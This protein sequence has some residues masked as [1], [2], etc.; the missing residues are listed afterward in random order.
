MRD[1]TPFERVL[2]EQ[3]AA[4]HRIPKATVEHPKGVIV[5]GDPFMTKKLRDPDYVPYCMPCTPMQRLRRV[6]DG[7]ECPTCRN[8]LNYDLTRFNGNINVQYEA[9]P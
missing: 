9:Q 8:K 1:L 6:A 7:F 2:A 4:R 3:C 5:P